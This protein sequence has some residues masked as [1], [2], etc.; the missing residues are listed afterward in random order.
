MALVERPGKGEGLAGFRKALK[1][2]KG[3]V[4]AFD[5]WLRGCKMAYIVMGFGFL[6]PMHHALIVCFETPI[7]FPISVIDFPE[8][9]ISS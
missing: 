5:E 6:Y 9:L 1:T 4:A 2:R 8:L 7:S 3:P